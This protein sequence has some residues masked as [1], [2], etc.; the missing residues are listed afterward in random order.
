[1][2][3]SSNVHVQFPAMTE[4][5]E[6]PISVDVQFPE[7][8]E[9]SDTSIHVQFPMDAEGS[10]HASP[11]DQF[12]CDKHQLQEIDSPRD[13]T[14]IP[15]EACSPR[16]K[17]NEPQ[18]E[19]HKIDGSW[20]DRNLWVDNLDW[21]RPPD[22]LPSNGW[23][24]EVA[25]E[26]M[27]TSPRQGLGNWIGDQHLDSWRW[28]IRRKPQCYDWFEHFS[29]NNEIRDLLERYIL[30]PYYIFIF[31]KRIPSCIICRY[32]FAI[33]LMCFMLDCFL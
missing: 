12:P 7:N 15:M 9:S 22:S 11:T 16:P 6:F 17:H 28:S 13:S 29:D 8:A 23:E 21:Q 1:M 24:S 2:E 31:S 18:D 25:V 14:N 3:S 32:S 5:T 30:F 4:S 33:H 19:N 20:D 27:E 26:D 10:V